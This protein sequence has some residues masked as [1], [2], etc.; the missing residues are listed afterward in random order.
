MMMTMSS[1]GSGPAVTLPR[2]ERE[3]CHDEQ[4]SQDSDEQ[5]LDANRRRAHPGNLSRRTGRAR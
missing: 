4:H 5:E 2:Q 1:L 3:Q